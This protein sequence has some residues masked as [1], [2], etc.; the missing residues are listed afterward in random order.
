MQNPIIAALLRLIVPLYGLLNL[1]LI[2]RGFNPLPF[3]EEEVATVFSGVVT[4]IGIVWAWWKNN[5][6]TKKAQEIQQY[7][8]EQKKPLS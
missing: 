4:F 1:F 2:S 8:E 5:T 7:F 6:I 3:S